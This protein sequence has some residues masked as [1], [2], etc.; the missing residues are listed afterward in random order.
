MGQ[1]ATVIP[2]LNNRDSMI[3]IQLPGT[4]GQGGLIPGGRVDLL[5]G[6]NFIDTEKWESAKKN[7]QCAIMLKEK[8]PAS[9]APEQEQSR[10]GKT[11]LEEGG[12][13]SKDNPLASLDVPAAVAVVG[14]M[15]N[16]GEMKKFL[17]QEVRP[18]VNTALR[19]KIAEIEKHPI[20][21]KKG[22]AVG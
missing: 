11:Y 1:T 2:V 10:V 8:I 12:P 15:L 22:P 7:S 4:N 17:D 3:Q 6:M 14:E 16:V 13:I 21:K 18:V 5:P 19:N 20:V 9:N